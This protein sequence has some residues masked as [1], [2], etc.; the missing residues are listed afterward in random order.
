MRVK[1]TLYELKKKQIT[2]KYAPQLKLLDDGKTVDWNSDLRV[3]ALVKAQN[4]ELD[5]ADVWYENENQ[6]ATDRTE[7][8]TARISGVIGIGVLML[9]LMAL[10]RGSI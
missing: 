2:Q 5:A 4:E 8:N 1:D 3:A 6:A 7:R 10:A 9:I